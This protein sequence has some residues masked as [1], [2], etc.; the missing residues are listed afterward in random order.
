MPLDEVRGAIEDID[1]NIIDC[2]VQRMKLAE[3]VFEIKKKENLAI[4][5]KGRNKMVL[6][7]VAK[8][9]DGYGLDSGGIREIFEILIKMSIERQKQL[10]QGI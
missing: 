6:D 10:K 4:E 8:K 9:A 3:V 5:D 1:D 7:R 2:I